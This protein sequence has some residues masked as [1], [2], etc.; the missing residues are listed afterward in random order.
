MAAW[1]QDKVVFVTGGASGIGAAV[2]ALLHG[3]GA[4]LALVDI[5]AAAADHTAR[6]INAAGTRV[7]ALQADVTQAADLQRAVAHT[8]AAFGRVDVVWANAGIASFGPLGATDPAAWVRNIEVN[9]LGVFHTVRAAL[10]EVQRQRGHVA[11]TASAASF[12]HAPC[13]SAYSATKAGVE[14][15]CDSLRI[16]VAHHGVTVGAIHPSWVATPLIDKA[17]QSRAFKRLRASMPGALGRNMPLADAAAI[18]A[19][20]I[21]Q[22]QRHVYAPGYVRFVHWLRTLL[23]TEV[24]EHHFRRAMPD[25]EQAFAQDVA[26]LGAAQASS[27]VLP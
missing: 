15:L 18:V 3:Q 4:Q 25:I 20:G 13:L 23:H 26:A 14:A 6:T 24:A 17:E 21:A 1:I 19:R 2:A 11:V 10:P 5:N 9:L 22:R 7:L 12:V 16:E 27:S 8:K